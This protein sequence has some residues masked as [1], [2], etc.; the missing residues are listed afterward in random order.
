MIRVKPE[1][2][3][4]QTLETSCVT[5]VGCMAL[6][7]LGEYPDE[8]KLHQDNSASGQ[9]GRPLSD[10]LNFHRSLKAEKFLLSDDAVLQELADEAG[11]CAIALMVV[12]ARWEEELRSNGY[13]P[14]SADRPSLHAVL[15]I[16]IE[17]ELGVVQLVVLDPALDGCDH[18][19]H[20]WVPIYVKLAGFC[21]RCVC[22]AVVL[23]L[24]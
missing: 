16:G 1:H 18:K 5:V 20:R 10:L 17:Y 3:A 12:S 21:R 4:R 19:G 14:P 9:G 22:D 11:G 23:R 6:R 8:S 13:V 7:A 2:H 24:S 15:L